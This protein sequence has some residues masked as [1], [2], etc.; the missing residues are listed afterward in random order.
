MR[1]QKKLTYPPDLFHSIPS[2]VGVKIGVYKSV[3]V[4]G[5]GINAIYIFKT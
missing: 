2:R 4:K 3:I 5:I 1:T